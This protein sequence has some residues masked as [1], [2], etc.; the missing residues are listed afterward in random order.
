M[1]KQ[2]HIIVIGASAGGVQALRK[3]VNELPADFAAPVFIVQHIPANVESFL[4]LIL[5]SAGKLKAVHPKDGDKIENGVIYIAPPD[6]HMLIDREKI[7]IK[8]GPKENNFRPSVDALMRSAAYNF[9]PAVIGIVLTGMLFDGTSGL[10]SVKRLGGMTIIQNP[11]EAEFPDMPKNVLEYV[12]VDY[13]TSLSDLASLINELIRQPVAYANIPNGI[14]K[15]QMKKEIDIAAAQKA[16]EKGATEM[17]NCS[18]LTCPDCGGG[19]VEIKEGNIIRYRCHTGHAY[20]DMALLKESVENTEMKLWQA[21]RCMEETIMLLEQLNTAREGNAKEQ[22]KLEK[23]I[24]DIR[25]RAQNLHHVIIRSEN[26]LS[27]LLSK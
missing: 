21:L 16:F 26:P 23:E 24:D 22:L 18:L 20:I 15:E 19:M 7:M 9:G 5:E 6:H 8:R 2:Q 12:D 4:P 1:D 17:G 3:F 14:Q 27:R 25:E 13:Q 10:W 11:D